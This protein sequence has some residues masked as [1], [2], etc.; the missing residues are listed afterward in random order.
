MADA[1]YRADR[2]EASKVTLYAAGRT[3]T[4]GYNPRFEADQTMTNPPR[5]IFSNPRPD[6]IQGH[7]AAPFNISATFPYPNELD[8][9]TIS[10]SSGSYEVTIT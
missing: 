9:V 4:T 7:I 6:G 3:P 1:T 8:V 2:P 10:D 5:F